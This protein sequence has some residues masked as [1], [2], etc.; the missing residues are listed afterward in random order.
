MPVATKN[1]IEAYNLM[2]GDNPDL[3]WARRTGNITTLSNELRKNTDSKFLHDVAT[4][5]EVVKVVCTIV[6]MAN[7]ISNMIKSIKNFVNA[8]KI[9]RLANTELP[10]SGSK[11][12]SKVP[13]WQAGEPAR[14]IF[15][16]GSQEVPLK[17]GASG[18]GEFLK[19]LPG[20]KG[21]GLNAQI[22]SAVEHA[23][24]NRRVIGSSPI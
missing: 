2:Q 18:P 13:E 3:A 9:G 15:K 24:V 21:T 20:G 1:S 23:A 12:H 7:G 17:S 8:K 4:G 6:V 5:I 16:V 19:T 22:P 10:N 14:G 11:L